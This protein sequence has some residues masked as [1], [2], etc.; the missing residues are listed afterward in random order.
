MGS[1]KYDQVMDYLQQMIAGKQAHAPIPSE[2][3][4]STNLSISRMTVR[5]GIEELCRQGVLYRDGN[6]GT[7]VSDR[8]LHASAALKP[9]RSRILFMDTVYDSTSETEVQKAFNLQEHDRLFR[10]VRLILSGEHPLRVEEIYAPEHDV[11]DEELG[12][13][14]SFLNLDQ[15][16]Q[17]GQISATLIPM[18]VPAKYA[19]LLHLS[20]GV[21]VI[22]REERILS[23]AQK[24]GF[25][26]R[27]I[28][29][30]KYSP[31]H[32]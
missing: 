30:P 12:N 22:C 28:Y 10:L 6:K 14:S 7:F 17:S 9:E 19:R 27:T 25:Y 21:P 24:A 26:V 4:I 3:E 5:K 15:I 2:R 1:P 23:P 13:L 20:Q 8:A 29:N 16:R 32:V 11:S 31:I 18:L